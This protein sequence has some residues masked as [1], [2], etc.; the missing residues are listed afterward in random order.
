MSSKELTTAREVS[1]EEIRSNRERFPRL[2]D[3]PEPEACRQLQPILYK[4]FMIRGQNLPAEAIAYMA[5]E[6]RTALMQDEDGAGLPNITIEE[7]RR[8]IRSA[9]LGNRGELYGINVASLY[10]VLKNY[11][12]GAGSR[13]EENIRKA[14][15]AELE[16]AEEKGPIGVL[17]VR[18]FETVKKAIN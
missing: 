18:Y 6:L 13:A 14:R 2:K 8:E 12:F 11:A 17:F 4:A 1:L 5:Q 15:V 7:I 16:T 10:Q 3:I 9:A